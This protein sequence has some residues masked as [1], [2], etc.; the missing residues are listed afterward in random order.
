MR[1]AMSR[2]RRG[3]TRGGQSSPVPGPAG[4]SPRAGPGGVAAR[5]PALARERAPRPGGAAGI[6][7]PRLSRRV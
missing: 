6:P 1:G 5:L 7:R 3:A 2:D 4:V